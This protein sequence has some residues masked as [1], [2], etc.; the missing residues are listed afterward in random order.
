M[1]NPSMAAA[2]GSYIRS[3]VD[4]SPGLVQFGF[5]QGLRPL[6][7]PFAVSSAHQLTRGS[8]EAYSPE[9]LW[10]TC[11][12]DGQTV[13]AGT[14]LY[15]LAMATR[16]VGQPALSA[17]PYNS[18]LGPGTEAV[19]DSASVVQWDLSSVSDLDLDDGLEESIERALN[20][21]RP[22]VMILQVS[23]EFSF[24][25]GDAVVAVPESIPEFQGHHAVLIIGISWRDGV[26]SVY[27]VLNSWGDD[28]ADGG[29]TW[30]P[31]DY[32]IKYGAQLAT[33]SV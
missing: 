8:E 32:I 29:C 14:S 27:R 33:L 18:T 31:V 15:A 17:W 5:P 26:G 24:V 28:W 1:T 19:P 21:G 30:I 13:E 22:V 6:C 4:L 2:G 10:R 9:A 16:S 25:I 23:D 12:T 3:S 20:T 11:F 7:L